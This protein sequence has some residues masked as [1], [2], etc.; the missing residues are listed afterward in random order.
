[1]LSCI[2]FNSLE[3]VDSSMK[4]VIYEYTDV[5]NFFF[6]IDDFEL[7]D[8][9]IKYQTVQIYWY[10]QKLKTK[11]CKISLLPFR[12]LPTYQTLPASR[13]HFIPTPAATMVVAYLTLGGL[14]VTVIEHCH[15]IGGAIIT[16]E[17]ILLDDE[18]RS[19]P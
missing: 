1:M 15:V 8:I 19:L 16:E 4:Y 17:L 7:L 2:L 5:L 18:F 13:H 6:I 10:K 3:I 14:I 9:A 11:N 12:S